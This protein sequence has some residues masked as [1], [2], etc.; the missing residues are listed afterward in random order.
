MVQKIFLNPTVI[1]NWYS[2]GE[3]KN[4][5]QELE[6]YTHY[7]KMYT[8]KGEIATDAHGNEIGASFRIPLDSIYTEAGRQ[9]SSIIKGREKLFNNNFYK[10][11]LDKNPLYRTFKDTSK[12]FCFVSYYE[13]KHFYDSH[14]DKGSFSILIW[15]YK[16]PK[17]FS[18][19]D[20]IF[21]DLDLKIDCKHNRLVIFPGFL[22]H[23]VTPIKM[24]KGYKIGDGR[25]TVTH[26]IHHD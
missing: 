26:F 11:I 22:Y 8:S 14:P 1:D 20:L 13:D 17:K 23:E 2:K 5:F 16:E 9:M 21:K 7:D 4:I 15:L 25:Y 6:Y 18:G 3:L 19:G 24:K 12:D 10:K